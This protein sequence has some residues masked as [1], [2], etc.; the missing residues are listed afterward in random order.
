M[1]VSV[2][3]FVVLLEIIS[4]LITSSCHDASDLAVILVLNVQLMES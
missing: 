4:F 3:D 2:L 1:Q